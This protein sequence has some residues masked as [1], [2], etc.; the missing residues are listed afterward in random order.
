MDQNTFNTGLLRFL[1]QSPTQYHAVD[2]LK[3]IL[4]EN[5][6]TRLYEK[7]PWAISPGGKYYIIRNDA[8]LIA[9]TGGNAHLPET[10]FRMIGAHTDSP[11][12]KIKPVPESLKKTFFQTGVEVYGGP[13]LN[14]WFDRDLSIAGR[15]SWIKE[16]SSNHANIQT[17]L[18]DFNDPVAVIPSLAI[19]L[20]REANSNRSINKQKDLPP[21][22]MLT[23][24]ESVD[25]RDILITRLAHQ[26]IDIDE[27]AQLGFDLFYYDATPPVYTG[28][29]KEFITSGRLDNLVSC[30][31]G[32]RALT[33]SGGE[34]PALLVCND[35]EE[36]GSVSTS[37]ASGTF[38]KSVLQRLC[39]HTE[40]FSRIADVSFMISADNAHGVHP[41]FQDKYEENHTPILNSGPVIK[42]NA[43]QRYA[44][45]SITGS[46]FRYLCRK[47]G[48]SPQEFVVRSDM[49]CGSTIGPL[50]AGVTGIKTIDA[51][52]P[53]LAM[54]SIRETIGSLDAFSFYSV[55]KEHYNTV[56]T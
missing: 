35:H 41:N 18:I 39:R 49:A 51:G 50:T 10:G 31:A 56:L 14:S 45:D 25:F 34:N 11:G 44:T 9:F 12:L 30:Y 16:N 27:N 13:L 2:S 33:G 42:I 8:S 43:N 3:S 19:H 53:M 17:A 1:K 22:V 37:G 6:F 29:N 5:G 55:M 26:G 15:I 40:D 36:V 4:N 28:L 46:A 24:E 20:D 54:H 47:A 48:V 52:I 21:V 32:V 23:S 38:L 7:D